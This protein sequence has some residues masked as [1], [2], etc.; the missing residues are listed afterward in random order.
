MGGLDAV[1][2]HFEWLEIFWTQCMWYNGTASSVQLQIRAPWSSQCE[3][4]RAAER[5]ATFRTISSLSFDKLQFKALKW[6]Y[7]IS[8]IRPFKDR[9]SSDRKTSGSNSAAAYR[10]LCKVDDP[11]HWRFGQLHTGI[12][13]LP[14]IVLPVISVSFHWKEKCLKMPKMYQKEKTKITVHQK[15][16]I[17]DIGN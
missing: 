13:L 3:P 1:S 11:S 15:R 10:P 5:A 9:E 16:L 6:H 2:K 8:V 14:I 7:K 17:Y 12:P 4:V